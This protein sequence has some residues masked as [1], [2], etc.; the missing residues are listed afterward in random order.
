MNGQNIGGAQIQKV[1]CV[2][3][4]QP[5]V[6]VTVTVIVKQPTSVGVP[7]RIP[8]TNVTPVGSGP[9]YENTGVPRMPVAVKTTQN[10]I[11]VV[12]VLTT[13]GTTVTGGQMMQTMYGR[14]IPVQKFWSVTVTVTMKHPI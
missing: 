3:P 13:G 4:V 8:L 6:S 1:Y 14:L 2:I 11:P 12:P 10:W 5:F 7:Q 9:V